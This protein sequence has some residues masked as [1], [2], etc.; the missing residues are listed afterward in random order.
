MDVREKL[1]ELI[2]DCRVMEGYGMDLVE[3]QADYL[4]SN[5][6]TVQEYGHGVNMTLSDIIEIQ[7][8]YK[9]LGNFTKKQLCDAMIPYREKF[10][11]T[12]REVLAIARN[13]LTLEEIDKFLKR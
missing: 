5:G 13:E 3:R 4:I 7:K 9:A 2:N 8:V 10:E 6:V 12:D 1:V 11:L